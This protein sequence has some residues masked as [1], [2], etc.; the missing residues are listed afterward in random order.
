M[1]DDKWRATGRKNLAALKDATNVA[2]KK[3]KNN[4]SLGVP[5]DETF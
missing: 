1:A 2:F 3:A 4:T 5:E